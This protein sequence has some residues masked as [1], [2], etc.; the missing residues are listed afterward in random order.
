MAEDF[1]RLEKHFEGSNLALTAVAEV[2]AKMDDRLT[3]EEE[4][5]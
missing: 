4:E 1:T 5:G 2:L 3:K